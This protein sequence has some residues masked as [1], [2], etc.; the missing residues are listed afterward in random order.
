MADVTELR[1]RRE[2]YQRVQV[3]LAGL[4]GV[5]LLVTLANLVI[6]K[7]RPDLAADTANA[8]VAQVAADNAGA[9]K[10][11]EPLADLGVTP[12]AETSERPAPSMPD[13]QPDP[14]LQQPMD[15]EARPPQ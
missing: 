12:T 4:A 3:G 15:R 9:A 8:G 5:L 14:R 7:A 11:N 13:L 10:P 2:G 6:A 1:A